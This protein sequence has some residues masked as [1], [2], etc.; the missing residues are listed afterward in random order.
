MLLALIARDTDILHDLPS[1]KPLDFSHER[2]RNIFMAIRRLMQKGEHIDMAAIHG[3]T[4]LMTPKVD[5]RYLGEVLGAEAPPG[6][7]MTYF[8]L[9]R[10]CRVMRSLRRLSG[11]INGWLE[12]PEHDSVHAIMHAVESE[13]LKVASEIETIE[14]W[15]DISGIMIKEV[16]DL[17]TRLTTPQIAAQTMIPTGFHEIDATIL[18]LRPSEMCV[19]AARPSA[20]KTAL[21][22]QIMLNAKVKCAFFSIEM[23]RAEVAR[24]ICSNY[25]RVSWKALE[26]GVVPAHERH[27]F[28][29]NINHFPTDRIWI[30]DTP[31]LSI[32]DFRAKA[33]RL[34]RQHGC[35]LIALDYLQIMRLP[36]GND[37]L[38]AKYGELCK[39]IK[40]VLKELRVPGIILAQLNRDIERRQGDGQPKMADIRE[41]GQLEQDADHIWILT[42]PNGL[43]DPALKL[44]CLKGRN[45]GVFSPA[46]LVFDAE[47]QHIQSP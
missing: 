35:Q 27:A 4:S 20:G 30:D 41:C 18:G 16:A 39:G 24:R 10:D 6:L 15:E 13:T 42:R 7:H 23:D 36:G 47:T 19:I 34:V 45:S 3:K 1:L 17:E 29:A 44:W 32:E 25:T 40:A 37:R 12:T 21:A 2:N 22:V 8:K 14:S 43:D 11:K 38:D 31:A 33:R 26:Q 46:E 28:A 5:E 9:V